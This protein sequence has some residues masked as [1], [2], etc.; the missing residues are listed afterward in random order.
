MDQSPML[1]LP[2]VCPL[3]KLSLLLLGEKVRE[4]PIFFKLSPEQEQTLLVGTE[5]RSGDN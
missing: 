4:M 5:T 3:G 1:G 2:S